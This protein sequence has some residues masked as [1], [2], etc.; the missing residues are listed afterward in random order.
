MIA[1]VWQIILNQSANNDSLQPI[2]IN[3][4]N[5]PSLPKLTKLALIARID[6]MYFSTATL[7]SLAG[8]RW[9]FEEIL[10]KKSLSS[11]FATFSKNKF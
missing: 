1:C 8:L 7:I 9:L 2:Q 11:S 4:W 6:L 3:I 10:I 5:L